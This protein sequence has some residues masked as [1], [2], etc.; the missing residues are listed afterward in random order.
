MSLSKNQPD[1]FGSTVGST[2][3]TGLEM[4]LPRACRCGAT[5][6]TIGSSAGPHHASLKCGC[7]AH[8]GWVSYETHQFLTGI[9]D[10]FGRPDQPVTVRFK[11]SRISANNPAAAAASASETAK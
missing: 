10:T 9:I 7:G 3:L 8:R 1:L 2:S 5:L 11:D 4:V 6:A